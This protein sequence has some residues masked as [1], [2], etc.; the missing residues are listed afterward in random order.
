MEVVC[1]RVLGLG[2]VQGGL[3]ER[4]P[5]IVRGRAAISLGEGGIDDFGSCKGRL[6]VG[7]AA[8]WVMGDGPPKE[9]GGIT[10]SFDCVF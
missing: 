5:V 10:D 4:V 9:F 8:S 6:G 2:V 1:R 3:L 7:D